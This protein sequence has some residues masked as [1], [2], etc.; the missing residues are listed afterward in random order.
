MTMELIADKH[1]D[2]DDDDED[3]CG[4]PARRAPSAPQKHGHLGKS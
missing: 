2:D 3:R 1:G 4:A